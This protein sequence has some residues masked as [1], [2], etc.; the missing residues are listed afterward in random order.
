MISAHGAVFPL[1]PQLKRGQTVLLVNRITDEEQKCRVVYTEPKRGGKKKVAVEF[2][3]SKASNGDFWHVY[4]SL[5][6]LNPPRSS[7]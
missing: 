4:C 7:D 2:T 1:A 3:D 5:F 6:P